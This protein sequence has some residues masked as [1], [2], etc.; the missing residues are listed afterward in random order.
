M[1][2]TRAGPGGYTAAGHAR[3]REELAGVRVS[4]QLQ[5]E[6]SLLGHR[7]DLRIVS[8]E[9]TEGRP[10]VAAVGREVR[11]RAR[12]GV[13]HSRGEVDDAADQEA[14]RATL[15]GDM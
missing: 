5:V 11:T 10:R 3:P 4:R 9:Q 1:V 12:V 15:D 2:S 6:A 13:G 7:R 8:Q 14:C